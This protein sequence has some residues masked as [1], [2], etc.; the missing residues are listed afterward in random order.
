MLNKETMS[1]VIILENFC[2]DLMDVFLEKCN[3]NDFNKLSLVK[4]SEIVDDVHNKQIDK[5][6]EECEKT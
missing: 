4:I 1:K 5:L 2:N 3:Y 6:V